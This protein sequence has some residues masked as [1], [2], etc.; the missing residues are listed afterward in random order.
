MWGEEDSLVD[1]FLALQTKVSKLN[2]SIQ[3]Q[4]LTP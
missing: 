1:E 2:P 4:G 3:I